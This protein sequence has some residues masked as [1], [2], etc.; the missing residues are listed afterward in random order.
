[1]GKLRLQLLRDLAV[2][3]WQFGAATLVVALGVALFGGAYSSYQNL[4]ASYAYS[5]QRLA[6]ADYWLLVD[7][8]PER[9]VSEIG[10]LP[11]VAAAEGRIVREV[12]LHIPGSAGVLARVISVPQERPASAIDLVLVE[13]SF[14]SGPQ[15]REVL[16]ERKFANF[17]GFRPGD[18]IHFKKGNERI[19]FKVVGVVI[20]PEYIW[21]T[22]SAAEMFPSPRAFGV[23]FLP[24]ERAEAFF[25][26]QGRY[27][28]ILVRLEP[29]AD[30][31][32]LL[33]QMGQ[34]LRSYHIARLSQRDTAE[35]GESRRDAIRGY[36][37][38]EAV[39]LK[40]QPSN[41]ML[42]MDLESFHQLSLM[43][44]VM[45]LAAAAM[46]I[47]TVLSRLIQGQRP[48]IGLMVAMGYS[49]GQILGHYLGF[50][51]VVGLLGVA[52]GTGG[53]I[54]LGIYIGDMYS[55]FVNIPL[56]DFQVRGDILAVGA[57]A[58]LGVSLLAGLVPA[59]AAAGLRPAV[60]M[61][62]SAPALGRRP[63]VEALFPFL[64]RL[65]YTWKIP[66]RNIFR[67]P[68]RSFYTAAGVAVGLALILSSAS[69]FDAF[70]SAIDLEFNGIRQYDAQLSFAQLDSA[71]VSRKVA[72]Y[73]GVSSSQPLLQLP[74]RVLSEGKS[75]TTL[76]LGLPEMG[77]PY[78]L[79]TP[80]GKA[81]APSPE[82]ILLT[83]V[84]QEELGVKVGDT[85]SLQ[86]VAG[87]VGATRMP[88]VGIVE[89]PVGGMAF[90]P[91]RSVQDLMRQP[92]VATGLMLELEGHEGDAGLR[93]RLYDLPQ[94]AAINFMTEQRRFLD[95][96]LALMWGFIGVMLAFGAALA[97]AI[98]FNTIMVNTTE[99]RREIATLRTI[100]LSQGRIFLMATIENLL[101][102]LAGIALGL[103]LG[104]VMAVNFMKAYQGDLMS[105][106]VV[107][108]P[109][110]FI[111]AAAGILLVLL[112]SQIP[113]L[114][115][116]QRL[117]LAAEV[118][119]WNS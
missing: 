105:I 34:V 43:F 22:K 9:A 61:R 52:V 32:V 112:L 93:Q 57:G 75:K 56:R 91:L 44:P 3:K 53:G 42:E 48:Q 58:G 46:A 64:A 7:E 54:L 79:F 31:E 113:A 10:A 71:L 106:S 88:V 45:F 59:W 12:P 37:V 96:L 33:A 97:A 77:S 18:T 63:P 47:Y 67:N 104:Y 72:S 80:E 21:V 101:L 27:N 111:L 118:K 24:Q 28:E 51:L 23:V 40:D 84:L 19:P 86:P 119:D 78:R 20:S 92:G 87:V 100:G 14:F 103:P 29:G 30:R 117:D 76:I 62:P 26:S 13:G 4:K 6:M 116:I 83:R 89:Q 98:V 1:M 114:R 109:R 73:P 81:I 38:G 85:V 39:A 2:H 94:T 66:L 65:S 15:A 82:G 16:L 70:H 50:A 90:L 74:Y 115:L 110:T 102:G 107:L 35:V 99:R 108:L 55:G 36:R 5:Y 41:K 49:R 17:Q 69:F 68:R 95:D 60:A 11:G 8:A 25:G